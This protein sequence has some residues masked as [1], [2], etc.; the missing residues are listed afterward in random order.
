VKLAFARNAGRTHAPSVA[1]TLCEHWAPL[2][3]VLGLLASCL[4]SVRVQH[5][6]TDELLSFYLLSDPS[7]T[8]M[9][10]AWRDRING[11]P[12]LYF[13]AGWLWARAWGHGT[14]SLRLFT[15]L[16]FCAAL[17]LLW[18]TLRRAYGEVAASFAVLVSLF[19]CRELQFHNTEVRF[20]GLVF[21]EIAA[22]VAVIAAIARSARPARRLW[23]ANAVVQASLLTTHYAGFVY[24]GSLL[25]SGVAVL[26]LRARPSAACKLAGSGLAGGL[27]FL[28]CIPAYLHHRGFAGLQHD[29]PGLSAL[30][31]A[32]DLIYGWPIVVAC[33][34]GLLVRAPAGPA[35]ARQRDPGIGALRALALGFVLLPSTCWTIAQ[36]LPFPFGGR[37]LFPAVIAWCVGLAEAAAAVESRCP[38]DRQERWLRAA[39]LRGLPVVALCAPL[40]KQ[41]S[42]ARS[43]LLASATRELPGEPLP[44]AFEEIHAFLPR[45]HY[46]RAPARYFFVTDSA[47]MPFARASTSAEQ[48]YVLMERLA[49][50]YPEVQV[51][52]GE[53]FLERHARFLV[54]DSER[55]VWFE[56]VLRANSQLRMTAL[57]ADVPSHPLLGDIATL[58]LVE[59]IPEGDRYE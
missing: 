7:F 35:P 25:A 20:Y 19:L 23:L 3:G 29:A 58:W 30:L 44:I 22:G 51:T 15:A 47:S 56:R 1:R 16:C 26:V 21:L 9:L 18:S 39:V 27:A 59:R 32:H 46:T 37:Y 6:W 5:L 28:P 57:Q 13:I 53:S 12:P 50:R 45:L 43:P 54:A 14:A 48:E 42:G 55:F 10:D 31:T 34:I 24:A 49:A 11:S 17:V 38:R 33:T 8:G 36:L 40:V 52:S 2:A 41:W 4:S